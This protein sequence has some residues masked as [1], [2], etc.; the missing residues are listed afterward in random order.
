M[1]YLLALCL[2]ASCYI[3]ARPVD[4]I[5]PGIYCQ[6]LNADVQR[7]TDRYGQVWVCDARTGFWN[8]TQEY[9]M[10]HGYTRW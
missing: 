7:C 6:P 10:L 8:C 3:T 2:M 9:P 4:V 1:R 5:G